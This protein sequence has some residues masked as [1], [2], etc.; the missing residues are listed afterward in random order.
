M[1]DRSQGQVVCDV[2]GAETGDCSEP[3]GR[4]G[5]QAQIENCSHSTVG[6]LSKAQAYDRT[7]GP[8]SY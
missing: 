7:L 5:S 1:A 8:S 2:S 4:D 3:Q 6:D